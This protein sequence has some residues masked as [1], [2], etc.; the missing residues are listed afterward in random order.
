VPA[1]PHVPVIAALENAI[2]AARRH[3]GAGKLHL[4]QRGTLQKADPALRLDLSAIAKGYAV[5]EVSMYLQRRKEE[6][7]KNHRRK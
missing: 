6:R 3:V 7:K 2:A 5:D 1:D 4:D